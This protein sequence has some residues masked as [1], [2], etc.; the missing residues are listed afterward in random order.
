MLYSESVQESH[1]RLYVL[2]IVCFG[3][4]MLGS[5]IALAQ[6]MP[7]TGDALRKVIAAFDRVNLVGLGERHWSREDSEFRLQLIR[8]PEF[9]KRVND[10]VIE[11][12]N[13]LYQAVLDRYVNGE[14]VAHSELS[15]VWELT[16]QGQSSVWRSPIYEDLITTVRY[17]NRDLPLNRR[18]RIIAG[19]YPA[20]AMYFQKMHPVDRDAA[21]ANAIQREV[22]DKKHKA[23]V[24]FGAMHLIR[25]EP[26][27][28]VGLLKEDSRANWFLVAPAGGPGLPSA[29][30]SH[31]ATL[32]N[33]ALIMT[34]GEVGKVYSGYLM[35]DPRG[36]WD[37]TPGRAMIGPMFDACLYFGNETPQVVPMPR[38]RP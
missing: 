16:T 6:D 8:D 7:D 24:I 3:Q 11:F 25:T 5:P 10:I 29:I 12:G 38:L 15:Q 32:S 19:D 18:L 23:L 2:G 35:L 4:M 13:P 20:D 31:P 34:A 22:L 36:L 33:P 28:I 21:A 17:V 14:E 26:H 9:S 1:S 30:A 27:G 37:V